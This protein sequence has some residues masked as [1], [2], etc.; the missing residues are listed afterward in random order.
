MSLC[1]GWQIEHER[2]IQQTRRYKKEKTAWTKTR[3]ELKIIN[4]SIRVHRWALEW[5]LNSIIEV[6]FLIDSQFPVTVEVFSPIFFQSDSD[7][8]PI[9]FQVNWIYIVISKLNT[10]QTVPLCYTHCVHLY[11][12][13]TNMG[14]SQCKHFPLSSSCQSHESYRLACFLWDTPH[15]PLFWIYCH[16]TSQVRTAKGK[17]YLPEFLR[18]LALTHHGWL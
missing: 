16:A 11:K 9:T 3:K 4:N 2:A 6:K 17:H 8:L 1:W 5:R 10:G 15:P 13:C 12:T 18:Q 14:H 7:H